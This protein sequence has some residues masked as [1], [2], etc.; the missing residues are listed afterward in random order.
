MRTT[1]DARDLTRAGAALLAALTLLPGSSSHAAERMERAVIAL[2]RNATDND[3]EILFDISSGADGF[4]SLSVTAPDGRKV[5]EMQAGDSKLGIRHLTL[6][7]PEPPRGAGLLTDFP[8]GTYRFI[9]RSVAGA[10]LQSEATL[11]HA[12]PA[13]PTLT[14]PQADQRNV[15]LTGVELRWTRVPEIAGYVVVLEHERSGQEIRARLP[16]N[17]TS[18]V[19]PNG[20][21][22]A[23]RTYKFA[24][25]TLARD[26]NR[27]F[28]E[29]EFTTAR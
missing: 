25:G 12:L 11:S 29:A 17:V 5:F 13:A 19:V 10:E 14:N 2:E 1:L 9:G 21:L 3:L 8:A 27:T 15:A 20:F 28:A 7:S 23:G 22:I 24:V 18:L 16:A 26:G 4:A 6:E